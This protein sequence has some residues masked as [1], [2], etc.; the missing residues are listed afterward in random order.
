[1]HCWEETQR[2][3]THLPS[4]SRYILDQSENSRWDDK[5]WRAHV[6][7]RERK[8]QNPYLQTFDLRCM[9]IKSGE[10][11]NRLAWEREDLGEAT[12][13]KL[14]PWRLAELS[15]GHGEVWPRVLHH[16]PPIQSERRYTHKAA[17]QRGDIHTHTPSQSEKR[18]IDT[19]NDHITN[20]DY[21]YI[22]KYTYIHY[23]SKVWGHLEMSLF[24]D[25]RFKLIRNTV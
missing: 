23:R 24:F 15:E 1:M 9:I 17:N 4:L 13:V 10:N 14:L 21:V 7:Y 16:L 11:R 25:T 19:T 18:E 12:A 6:S 2:C 3:L 5:S 20:G 8:R 22:Y